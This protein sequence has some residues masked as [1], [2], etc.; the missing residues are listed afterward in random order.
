MVDEEYVTMDDDL[1]VAETL[2]AYWEDTRLLRFKE[3]QSD[4]TES[5]AGSE[6][7]KKQIE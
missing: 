7:D 5:A 2:D 1:P 4:T 3:G 6:A